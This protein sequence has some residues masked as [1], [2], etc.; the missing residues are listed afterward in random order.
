MSTTLKSIFSNKK[1]KNEVK[2]V[3][4][5]IVDTNSH[6]VKVW[7]EANKVKE[8]FPLLLFL[9]SPDAQKDQVELVVK[10]I[11]YLLKKQEPEFNKIKKDETGTGWN[12]PQI[13]MLVS[14]WKAIQELSEKDRALLEKINLKWQE[15]FKLTSAFSDSDNQLLACKYYWLAKYPEGESKVEYAGLLP[16][17]KPVRQILQ[18]LWGETYDQDSYGFTHFS[19]KLAQELNVET[20]YLNTALWILGTKI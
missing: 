5:R 15:L 18:T 2:I 7:Q 13:S 20:L 11:P 12:L 3:H 9:A 1:I 10:T 19:N 14:R 16:R 4:D 6:F 8:G 17:T